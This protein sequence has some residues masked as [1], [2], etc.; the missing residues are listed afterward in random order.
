MQGQKYCFVSFQTGVAWR[1]GHSFRVASWAHLGASSI[2]G[3]S[4]QLVCANNSAVTKNFVL[5]EDNPDEQHI[6]NSNI[7]K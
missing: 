3:V 5:S 7:Q 1:S 6:Q 2:P 4:D